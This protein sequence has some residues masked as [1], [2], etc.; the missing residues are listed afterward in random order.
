MN[1]LRYANRVPLQFQ[2]GACAITQ[3]IMGTNWRSYGLSQSR[4]GLPS[5]PVTIFVH[6][7]NV[8]V[9]FTSES[10]EAV[11]SYPEIQKEIRLAL[12]AVGRK[13]AMYVRRRQKVKQEG[14]RRNIFL[15]YL[16]EVATAVN[17]ISGADKKKLYDQL[18]KV[19]KRKTAQ[20]DMKFDENGNP[21]FDDEAEEDYGDNVLIVKPETPA[22]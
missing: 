12:Q 8:W 20:A 9:P 13:L 6:M 18:L 21:I 1:V 16:G 11:A 17:E 3:T 10:K 5:G 14:E 7:A 15:R 4:C 2:P 22:T 19:A